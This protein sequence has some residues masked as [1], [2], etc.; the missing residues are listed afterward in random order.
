M[1]L[2]IK[3]SLLGTRRIESVPIKSS[4]QLLAQSKYSVK[5]WKLSLTNLVVFVILVVK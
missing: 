4:A 3:P 5:K 2:T 1:G